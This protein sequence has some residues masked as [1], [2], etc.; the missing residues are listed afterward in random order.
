MNPNHTEDVISAILKKNSVIR[1]RF[2]FR[3]A[4]IAMT[5]HPTK[6]LASRL[7][8]WLCAVL[9]LA[10]GQAMAQA[11]SQSVTVAVASNF[12]APMQ[13]IAQVFERD[14][15]Y[16]AKLSFGGTGSLYAQ[17]RNGAPFDV[18]LAADTQTPAKLVREQLA[19]ADTRFTYAIGQLV[20]WS[21]DS[22][23]V[24]DGGAVLRDDTFRKIAM[25]DP[26]LAPYGAA[27]KQVLEG[28]GLY[29]QIK[30][31]IVQ[32]K[33]IGQTFQF[34]SSGNA[35]LGFVALSQVY[36]D[37][38]LTAGSGWLVPSDQYDPIK[39]DAVLLAAAQDNQA[40]LALMDY[41]KGDEAR[42]I[43]KSFGYRES[44]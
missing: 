34:V 30:P 40:A 2:I 17:I 15:G 27:A 44:P 37:G 42:K 21:A 24:D 19:Q 16:Q 35:A 6:L 7:S 9:W 1:F 43:I 14:T 18:F 28:M 26:K 39:Q 29:R 36:R 38:E 33:N 10:P 22:K 11:L 20:L 23:R 3:I 8:L 25:A 12:T 13:Q 4:Q 32:G 31:K 5:K 41:L